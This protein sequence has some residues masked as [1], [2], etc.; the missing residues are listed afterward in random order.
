MRFTEAYES[1]VTEIELTSDIAKKIKARSTT[2]LEYRNNDDILIIEHDPKTKTYRVVIVNRANNSETVIDLSKKEF[3]EFVDTIK[4][5]SSEKILKNKYIPPVRLDFHN[6]EFLIAKEQNN[7]LSITASQPNIAPHINMFTIDSGNVS[8]FVNDVSKLY[9]MNEKENSKMNFMK[10]LE[11][12]EG[13][14]LNINMKKPLYADDEEEIEKIED[15]EVDDSVFDTQQ[16]LNDEFKDDEELNDDELE[17][18]DQYDDE[19]DFDEDEEFPSEKEIDDYELSDVS[20]KEVKELIDRVS[21]SKM[22][23]LYTL[24]KKFLG[25]VQEN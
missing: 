12:V 11:L 23:E 21:S 10:A 1:F 20:S 6:G 13:D 19:E 4:D 5:V 17:D 25:E 16:E 14:E 9:L 24:I 7:D 8:Q 2:E 22:R 3:I 18:V 15:E